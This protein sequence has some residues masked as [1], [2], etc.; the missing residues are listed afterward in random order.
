M[1]VLLWMFQEEEGVWLAGLRSEKDQKA[2]QRDPGW[3]AQGMEWL[4]TDFLHIKKKRGK[5]GEAKN[6]MIEA[7]YK[8][9]L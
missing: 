2:G 8:T 5:F 9:Y 3:Y 6:W 7:K 1:F 4:Q